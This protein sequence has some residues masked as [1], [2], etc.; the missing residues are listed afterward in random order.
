MAVRTIST[1][2]SLEGEAEYKRIMASINAELGKLGSELKLVESRF[3]GNAN[4]MAALTAKGDVLQKIYNEQLKKLDQYVDRLLAAQEAEEK[5]AAAGRELAESIKAQKNV[6]ADFENALQNSTDG[7]A[8]F[9]DEN[10][11]LIRQVDNAA[12][13]LQKLKYELLLLESAFKGNASRQQQAANAANGYEKQINQAEIQLNKLNAEIKQNEQYIN[14]ARR[15]TDG[16]ATSIDRFGKQAK[17]A[18]E[19]SDL[20][21]KIFAG[22]F[23][24]NIATQAL[25]TLWSALKNVA[26]AAFDLADDLMKT[27]DVTGRS[28]EE[29]QKLQYVADDIGISVDTIQGAQARL[30]RAMGE[31]QRGTER[32]IEAFSKLGVEYKNV[33]GSLRDVNTVMSES[34]EALN[35]MSNETERDALALEIFGRSALEL[36]PLIKA[37]AEGIAELSEEAENV[38]AVMSE[39][40]VKALD[41]FGDKIDHIK[42]SIKAGVGEIIAAF[43]GAGTAS[44]Q[45]EMLAGAINQQQAITN[46]IK[47]YRDLT[48][49]LKSTST[50]EADISKKTTELNKIKKQ[51]IEVSGGVVTAIGLE[52]GTFDDQV[53]VLEGLV[54]GQK[55]LNE[56]RL[57]AIA[58]E[59]AGADA[60][61]RRSDAIRESEK[62]NGELIKALQEANEVASR[63]GIIQFVD[64]LKVFDAQAQ[65]TSERVY[66][67]QQRQ[68]ALDQ[69]LKQLDEGAKAAAAAIR[70]LAVD[71]GYTEE[72]L[73]ALG[74]GADAVRA[75]LGGVADDTNAMSEAEKNAAKTVEEYRAQIDGLKTSYEEMYKAARESLD[76]SVGLWEEMKNGITKSAK[77]VQEAL[78][79]QKL[80]LYNYDT[81]LYDLQ[82]RKIEGVDMSPLVDSLAD[83]SKESMEILSALYGATDEEV[84]K[85]A[86]SFNKVNAYKDS[87]AGT[88]TRAQ[89]ELRGAY[90]NISSSIGAAVDQMNQEV[91]AKKAAYETMR[92]YIDQ[93]NDM[94]PELQ[95]T[96]GKVL[97]S[98]GAEPVVVNPKTNT[99]SYGAQGNYRNTSA[100]VSSPGEKQTIVVNMNPAPVNI[101]GR[102][103]AQITYDYSIEEGYI[104]GN[105][106]I[107]KR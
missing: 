11:K 60:E 22:G 105:S 99:T 69:E 88:L 54:E 72:Q 31:A 104:R 74:F 49:E 63:G 52:N 87:L 59:A 39:R 50:S 33:D 91:R 67:L 106:S 3:E 36:N 13:E 80:W 75:A 6:I 41:A 37:G 9:Y 66:G 56:Q 1:R 17:E 102:T 97:A 18:S 77:D 101:D 51:L 94:I 29:L 83:G 58:L 76:S 98:I 47:Q 48:K 64:N 14:E 62:V 61:K 25:N 53:V 65:S 68:A 73:I 40:A 32:Q 27:S 93:L 84:K 107:S 7:T 44:E 8:K 42:Q 95:A 12:D 90:D 24:A 30:T 15:S 26:S 78:D 86:E 35:R 92:G 45:M 10:G 4:S 38:G 2:L 28:V 23:F 79:S 100:G 103:V 89:S 55:E 96:Y 85:I 46:L 19:Q 70:M 34:L 21:G 16:C 81:Y 82:N 57:I 43:M 71:C 20:L 5:S